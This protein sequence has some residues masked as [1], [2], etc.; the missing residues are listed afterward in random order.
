[1][2]LPT[3]YRSNVV[4][5]FMPNGDGDRGHEWDWTGRAQTTPTGL[6][7]ASVDPTFGGETFTLNY[8]GLTRSDARTLEAFVEARA[9]RK[10]GFWCPTFQHEFDC[11]SKPGGALG[12]FFVREWG[13]SADIFPLGAAFRHVF[14]T[15]G[16]LRFIG[17]V[18]ATHDTSATDTDG[19]AVYG[20]D[21]G[22]GVG[23]TTTY[24]AGAGPLT[25]SDG[26]S[27]SRCLWVR[28]ADDPLTT[29]WTHPTLA[30]LTMRVV[31]V[32]KE[33]P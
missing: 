9:G 28:L 27:V 2:S 29:E 24:D 19:A 13:Y 23:D 17:P 1:M 7:T 33:S 20:Y 3:T 10:S 15:R 11:V 31:T 30:T 32:P 22:S 12:S 25:Q 6:T 16:A 8:V 26:L 14:L 5:P 21:L 18:T 4:I